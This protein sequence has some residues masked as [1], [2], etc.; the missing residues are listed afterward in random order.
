MEAVIAIDVL[1]RAGAD[2]TVASVEKQL[3]V[4]AC[5]GI[6]II[7]DALV[8]DCGQSFFD[9]ITLPVH[10]RILPPSLSIYIRMNRCMYVFLFVYYNF[11]FGSFCLIAGKPEE[12]RNKSEIFC[13]YNFLT[14]NKTKRVVEIVEAV[15]FLSSCFVFVVVLVPW[16]SLFEA[17]VFTFVECSLWLFM[18]SK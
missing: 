18:S 15:R 2:V 6:K 17:A 9:L 1:R 14:N 8:S 11:R 12:N 13:Y 10:T 16:T 3:R 7:A 5:H 4:D